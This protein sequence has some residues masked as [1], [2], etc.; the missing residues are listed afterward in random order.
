MKYTQGDMSVED[1]MDEDIAAAR[2]AGIKALIL[3]QLKGEAPPPGAFLC[4]AGAHLVSSLHR[5][6]SR[7]EN[8]CRHCSYGN[9]ALAA[10]VNSAAD[11]ADRLRR[12]SRAPRFSLGDSHD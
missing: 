3:R 2:R 4:V 8:I 7:A 11:E 5:D 1:M 10:F 12:M 9:A 6:T